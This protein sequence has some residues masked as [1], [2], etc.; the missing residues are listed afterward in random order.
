LDCDKTHFLHRSTLKIRSVILGR[1]LICSKESMHALE[2]PDIAFLYF[3]FFILAVLILRIP[4]HHLLF[5]VVQQKL[6]VNPLNFVF[7]Q[8]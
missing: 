4:Y 8:G 1:F 6:L 2:I 7:S 3:L 5:K